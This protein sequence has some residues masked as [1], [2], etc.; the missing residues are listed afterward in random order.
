[1]LGTTLAGIAKNLK[2]KARRRRRCNSFDY[3]LTGKR[4]GGVLFTVEAVTHRG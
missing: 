4:L 1:M 3:I 2:Q